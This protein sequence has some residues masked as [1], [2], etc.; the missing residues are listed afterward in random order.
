MFSANDCGKGSKE[1]NGIG[2]LDLVTTLAKTVPGLAILYD[3]VH[4]SE[5]SEVYLTEV[6]ASEFTLG[7]KYSTCVIL[8]PAFKVGHAAGK[9]PCT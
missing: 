2:L 4:T 1:L 9:L 6:S 7:G 5:E 3:L 8:L